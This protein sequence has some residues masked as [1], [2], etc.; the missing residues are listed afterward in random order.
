MHRVLYALYEGPFVPVPPQGVRE[1]KAFHGILHRMR[2][3]KPEPRYHRWFVRTGI[4]VLAGSAAALTLALFDITPSA[5]GLSDEATV[6]ST[7]VTTPEDSRASARHQPPPPSAED[8]GIG[9]PAQEFGRIVGGDGFILQPDHQSSNSNTFPVGTRFEVDLDSV[10]QVGL[11]GKI[12]ANFTP[13]S[14]VEWI[15]SSP[16]LIE[17]EIKRGIAAFRYDRKPSDPA[18]EVHT[19]SAVVRCVGTVFTV[20]VDE[21]DN[22]VVSVLRG[23]VEVLHP[24]THHPVAEVESGYRYDVGKGTYD[25]VGKIEVSS[26]LP[27]SME[28]D[29]SGDSI[30]I[31]DGRIPGN[32]NVP[33]LPEDAQFR[34]LAHVPARAGTQ[35]FKGPSIRVIGRPGA[36]SRAE[37]L[38]R[39]PAAR[40]VEDEGYDLL[41]DLVRETERTRRKEMAAHLASCKVLYDSHQT[42]YRAAKCFANFIGKYDGDPA[43]ADAWLMLG[44]LRMDYALDYK[45]AEVALS[46]FL[47]RAPGDPNAETAVY[48]MWLSAVEDGRISV[49][50]ARGRQYLQRYGDGRYV[51]KILERF[52]E[53]K[54]HI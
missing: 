47:R 32:W 27:L 5:L 50:L 28:V 22:T 15:T 6:V 17:L 36:S 3:E 25:N 18:L 53:L 35:T 38:R 31:A 42:R 8:G 29:D 24:K 12:V 4:L 43:A 11:V 48:R 44:I 37:P 45:A 16:A 19:A 1:E 39:K 30:V 14:E 9:H 21:G 54:S 40:Q 51:G 49:A 33:G 41:E 52:P 2:E 46:T 10:L 26:A 13:G 7:A 23:Q 20:Q 34:T